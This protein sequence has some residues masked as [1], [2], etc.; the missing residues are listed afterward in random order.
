MRPALRV[1]AALVLLLAVPAAADAAVK[2]KLIRSEG[3]RLTLD[4]RTLTARIVRTPFFSRLPTTEDMLY[5][6]R[7]VGACAT[8][9]VRPRAL[10]VHKRVY[11]PVGARTLTFGFARD[12]SARA[13][14]CL[15][16]GADG[17]DIAF[18]SFVKSEPQRLVAKGR[19]P[20]GEWWRLWAHR[21]SKMQPCIGLRTAAG[22][23]NAYQGCFDEFSQREA[24]LAVEHQ[25]LADRFVY[26]PVSRSAVSVRVRLHDGT[27][28]LATL[29]RRPA[30][31]R[32]FAQYFILV[33]P[34]EGP[35]VVGVRAVD[36]DGSTI[37]RRQLDRY[38]RH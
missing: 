32:A 3:V 9:F 17:G 38:S 16:E 14:W 26:G 37:A 31:S 29:H 7:V 10:L 33:L 4:G 12:I 18:A 28:E 20:S 13:R 11:W 8:R 21:S 34:R 24:T 1:F 22:R 19:G 35:K 25:T 6:D 27:V 2:S 15:L 5:G 30:G 36:A 23:P